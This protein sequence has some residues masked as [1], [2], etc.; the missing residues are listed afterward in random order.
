MIFNKFPLAW[1]P[2]N[3]DYSNQPESTIRS[4]AEKVFFFSFS[5]WAN[6]RVLH[7]RRLLTYYVPA[8]PSM[9]PTVL[10]NLRVHTYICT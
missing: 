7:A 10:P 6:Y 2:L 3:V 8:V 5:T 1:F 4:A 9:Y